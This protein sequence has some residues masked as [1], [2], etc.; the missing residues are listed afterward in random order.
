[1]GEM[2]ANPIQ[3][4]GAGL[5]VTVGLAASAGAVSAPAT[6]S[7]LAAESA[8]A[9]SRI[10]FISTP[11]VG[12][13]NEIYVMNADGSGKRR[14][15]GNAWLNIPAWSPDGRKIAFF[16]QG[17]GIH[18][19]NADGS[20]QRRLTRKWSYAPAWSPDG[21]KIAFLS[22]R[23]GNGEVYAMNADGSGQRNLTHTPG[24][25]EQG[26]SWAPAPGYRSSS[27]R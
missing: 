16:S 27:A 14:L 23:D 12:I 22:H 20:G 17:A 2:P 8:Q 15:T 11:R 21:R 5:V 1:M 13:N 26:A 19:A 9:S 4:L 3:F 7:R 6:G 24:V 25:P 10:A 18:V